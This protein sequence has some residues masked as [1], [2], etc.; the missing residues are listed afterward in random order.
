MK[1][2]D[3]KPVISLSTGTLRFHDIEKVF[4]I[5][6]D[7]GFDGVEMIVDG[8]RETADAV[9]LKGLTERYGLP[10]PSIHTPFGFV[11][12]PYWGKDPVCR[13]ESSIALAEDIG[14]EVLVIHMPFFAERR[15][16]RWV[17][18]GIPRNQEET[19]VK[20]AVENMP[21]AYKIFGRL[22]VAFGFGSFY[23]VDRNRGVNRLL[24]PFSRQCFLY[25]DWESLLRY[26]YIILDTTH[27]ATGGLDPVDA[28]ERIKERCVLIHLSNF[29]GREHQPLGRGRLDLEG[30][31]AH[32]GKSGYRGHLVL[33]YMPEYF[34]DGSE[35]TAREILAK[36]LAVCRSILSSSRPKE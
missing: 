7:L 15:Y 20:L 6:A 28:Y 32:L 2:K 23:G 4:E 12:T 9:Y 14:S 36:D 8:R 21:V 19:G 34:P 3:S 30:F 35:T 1:H 10:V 29:D 24:R 33:E 26:P 31:L 25:N 22:G 5:A 17:R 16:E 13:M 18:E 11:K 27:L